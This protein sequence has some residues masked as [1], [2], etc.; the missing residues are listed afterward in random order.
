MAAP[1]NP[2]LLV[3]QS[4][5]LDAQLS[6][7]GLKILASEANL[8]LR[9]MAAKGLAPG[10]KPAEV[11]ALLGIFQSGDTVALAESARAAL[12]KLPLQ[13]VSGTISQADAPTRALDL[14]VD[15]LRTQEDAIAGFSRH[16][17]T[18]SDSIAALARDCS[19][20]VSEIIAINEEK[21]LQYPPIIEALYR[22]KRTRMSTADR[23]MELAARNQVELTGIAAF[24]EIV[25]ALQGQLIVEPGA[26]S[27][28]DEQFFLHLEESEKEDDGVVED[29]HEID[30]LTGTEK[31]KDKH[32]STRIRIATTGKSSDRMKAVRD[33]NPLVRQAAAKAESLSYDEAILIASNFNSSDDVLRIIGNNRNFSEK[34]A[35][36]LKVVMNPRSP[37]ATSSRFLAFLRESE[38]KLVAQSKSVKGDLAAAARQQ[39]ARKK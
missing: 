18:A 15:A 26:R 37:L 24:K 3:S 13:I 20:A 22:N 27:F 28:D 16:P 21:L 17:N 33:K 14:L 5:P 11:V 2:P 35:F 30:E 12:Q 8:P 4:P 32:V 1:S 29:T 10:L 36:R 34:P 25:A 7:I 39:I 38:L 31:V 19:E 9:A 23:I 6:N